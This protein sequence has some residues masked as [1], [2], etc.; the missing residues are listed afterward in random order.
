MAD[1]S[2]RLLRRALRANAVFSLLSGGFM[3]V[4]DGLVAAILGAY[5]ALGPIHFVGLNLVVFAGLLFWLASR[6]TIPAKAG[7]AVVGADL[8]W[9]LGSWGAMGAGWVT[10]QG[11]WAVAAVADVVLLFAIVQYVGVRRMRTAPAAA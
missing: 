9:V 6:D 7:L 5:T 1:D 3:L 4:A 11:W 2:S 8:L 10:G